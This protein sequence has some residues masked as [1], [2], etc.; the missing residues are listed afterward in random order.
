MPPTIVFHGTKDLATPFKGAKSFYEA[1][2]QAGNHC[3]LV[4]QEDG[5]HSY[6][7]MS[8][9][10]YEKTLRNTETF[11]VAQKMLTSP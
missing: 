6:M 4:I 11:L 8:Q 1:M 3:E 2:Q 7:Y 5:G 9:P 10:L